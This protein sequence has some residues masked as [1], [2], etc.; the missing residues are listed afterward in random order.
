MRDQK[1]NK[2][3][4]GIAVPYADTSN[5]VIKVSPYYVMPRGPPLVMPAAAI[6]TYLYSL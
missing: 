3:M 1:L 6:K 2:E 4:I 5:R